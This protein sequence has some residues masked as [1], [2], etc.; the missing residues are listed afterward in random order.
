[1]WK[2]LWNI[3]G[4][5]EIMTESRNFKEDLINSNNPL[6]RKAWEKTEGWDVWGNEI[7]KEEKDGNS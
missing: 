6:L 1:M 4:E 7:K 2:N 5:F 3:K